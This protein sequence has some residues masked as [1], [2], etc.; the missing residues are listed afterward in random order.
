MAVEALDV[1]VVKGQQPGV[2]CWSAHQG[3][4]A[5]HKRYETEVLSVYEAILMLWVFLVGIDVE[6]LTWNLNI[7]KDSEILE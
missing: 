4:A 6:F 5:R 3:D 1:D 7:I 2:H